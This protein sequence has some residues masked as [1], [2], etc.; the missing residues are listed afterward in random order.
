M[1]KIDFLVKCL[2]KLDLSI[3]KKKKGIWLD[4]SKER[5]FNWKFWGNDVE[6][7]DILIIQ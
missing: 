1:L 7:I 2:Q 6:N 3:I 4:S 5:K